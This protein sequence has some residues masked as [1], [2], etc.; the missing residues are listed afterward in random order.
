[1]AIIT[2][3]T[4][5]EG[6][7]YFNGLGWITPPLE[8]QGGSFP[9][10]VSRS[11]IILHAWNADGRYW[12]TP[13]GAASD[14]DLIGLAVIQGESIGKRYTA[15]CPACDYDTDFRASDVDAYDQIGCAYCG[16]DIDVGG[17]IGE[18]TP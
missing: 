1:M 17:I 6:R 10:V 12:S 5:E 18:A 2:K 14:H 11:G 3:L 15:Y 13:E 16:A 9:F 4:L 7:R 8:A